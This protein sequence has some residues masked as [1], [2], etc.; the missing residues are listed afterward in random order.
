M[1]LTSSGPRL[2]NGRR[3]LTPPQSRHIALSDKLIRNFFK[4][5]NM[6]SVKIEQGSQESDAQALAELTREEL[7]LVASTGGGING[8]GGPVPQGV[9]ISG[10]RR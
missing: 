2:P 10:S 1:E 8:S 5:R 4:L 9:G 3:G 6:Q 7:G